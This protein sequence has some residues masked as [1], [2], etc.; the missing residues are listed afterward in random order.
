VATLTKLEGKIAEVLGLAMA[1]RAAAATV[2]E[3]LG[4]EQLALRE[5]LKRM[6]EEARETEK[7]CTAVAGTFDRKKSAIVAAA[8]ETR[9]EATDMMDTYLDGEEDPLDGFEF[10]IMAEAG[11]VG[12]WLVVTT[13]NQKAGNAQVKA[14]ADWA[15]AIQQRHFQDVLDAAV[16]LA[17]EE[18]PQELED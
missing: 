17:G 18:D 8:K 11:E 1:S 2:G 12:H 4:D 15:V 7:R 9:D 16:L 3:M 10:L 13:L 6:G 14:L 5:Q